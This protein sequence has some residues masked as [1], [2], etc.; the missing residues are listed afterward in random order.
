MLYK[1]DFT[2]YYMSG[3]SLKSSP[4]PMEVPAE[5]DE[6]WTIDEAIRTMVLKAS[7]GISVHSDVA[8]MDLLRSILRLAVELY[9]EELLIYRGD[10]SPR[11]LDQYRILYGSTDK[12]I[13]EAYGTIQEYR[14]KG[15]RTY[16]EAQS[17]HQ[18]NSFDEEIIFFADT[19]IC[20]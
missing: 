20:N 9:G 19:I 18:D 3:D 2:Y 17:V 14:V 12:S 11:P 4:S 13:A 7:R 16:S 6:Y 10:S 1:E 15:L 8:G 5:I